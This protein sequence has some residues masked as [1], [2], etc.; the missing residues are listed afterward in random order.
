MYKPVMVQTLEVQFLLRDPI[1]LVARQLLGQET[2]Q[3]LPANPLCCEHGMPH[4][5]RSSWRRNKKDWWI[6]TL[7]KMCSQ[8]TNCPKKKIQKYLNWLYT[9]K[10]YWKNLEFCKV[11]NWVRFICLLW[12]KIFDIIVLLVTIIKREI[13]YLGLLV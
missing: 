3:Y 5:E 8:H 13:D 2:H 9:A 1:L 11:Y 12:E 6:K 7:K 10:M 4:H